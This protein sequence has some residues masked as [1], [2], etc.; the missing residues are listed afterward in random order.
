MDSKLV[1][2]WIAA[3][4]KVTESKIQAM[5]PPTLKKIQLLSK[6]PLKSAQ[7]D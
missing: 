3:L 1:Q 6:R 4:K 2:W 7:T 5:M